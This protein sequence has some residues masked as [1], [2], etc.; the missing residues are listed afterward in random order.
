MQ[1]LLRNVFFRGLSPTAGVAMKLVTR[2]HYWLRKPRKNSALYRL[3]V[4]RP[5]RALDPEL[6]SF[7]DVQGRARVSPA[8]FR[9][10][11]RTAVILGA[12][13][14]NLSN[15]CDPH[16]FV[17]PH[18]ELYNFNLFDGYTYAAR[19]PLLGPTGA[20]SNLLTSIGDL[21]LREKLFERVLLIP[22]AHGG[23]TMA[24]WQPG[25]RVGARLTTALARVRRAGPTITHMLWQQ[26]ESEGAM[27]EA[28]GAA[29][30]AQFK[31]MIALVRR[32]GVEAP[33]FVAQC[34]LCRNQPNEIIRKAQR[35][36]VDPAAGIFAGP[37]TDSLGLPFRWDGCHLSAAGQ[38]KAAHLWVDRLASAVEHVGT[39][40]RN[41]RPSA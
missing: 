34:T 32:H 9:P 5:P 39:S 24:E 6:G 37:D 17:T 13:Q 31:A 35:D 33:V 26:G 23:S 14:S 2:A 11:A 40:G 36:V 7:C 20:R 19:E 25:G 1:S 21:L 22:I 15:E 29:W 4:R 3:I 41:T 18:P 30:A 8:L 10:D 12:G 38:Q 28:D 16:I 27:P